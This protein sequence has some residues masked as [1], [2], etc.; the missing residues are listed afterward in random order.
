LSLGFKVYNN[1]NSASTSTESGERS[2]KG[3]RLRFSI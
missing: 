2:Q 3:G 1:V